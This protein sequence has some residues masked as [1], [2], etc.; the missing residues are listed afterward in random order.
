MATGLLERR[1]A[2]TSSLKAYG[3]LSGGTQAPEYTEAQKAMNFNSR[4]SENYQKLIDPSYKAA[5]DFFGAPVAEAAPATEMYATAEEYA[6]ATLYPE[7]AQAAQAVQA[8]SVQ[9]APAAAP[10][11]GHERV[12]ADIF[13]A[14]SSLN[15]G[16]MAQTPVLEPVQEAPAYEQSVYEA[17]V[18]EEDAD[19][20]P[21]ATTIQYRTDL[22]REEQKT[23]TEEKKGYAMTAKAKLLMAVYAVVVVVV[24]A[25]II[26]NTSVLRTLD[27]EVIDREAALNSAMTRYEAVTEELESA[28]ADETVIDWALENGFEIPEAA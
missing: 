1:A 7:R 3:K 22:Y 13:R 16:R 11:Y 4:I 27:S 17:P 10:V 6:R 28:R 23:V 12:T 2:T 24:L 18:Y 9:E 19:L 26:V 5:E 25:L 15:A 20:A 8:A 14:D 21:T